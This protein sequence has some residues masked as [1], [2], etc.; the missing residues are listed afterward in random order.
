MPRLAHVGPL[1]RLSLRPIFASAL[2]SFAL[3]SAATPT[4][5]VQPTTTPPVI[6]GVIRPG[7]WTGTAHSDA[8]RQVIPVEEADPTERT[9]FWVTFDTNFIYVAIRAHDSDPARIPAVSLARDQDDGSDD[10]LRI[11]IDPF[12][13]ANDGYFFALTAAGG[14]HDGLIQNKSEGRFEWDGIWHGKA[15]V[16]AAGWSAEFAIPAKTISFDRA[17]ADWGFNVGRAIRSKNEAMRWSGYSRLKS[18]TSL[19][20]LGTLRGLAGLQQGRGLDFKPYASATRRSAPAPDEKRFELNPGFDLIW[21]LTP[22]LAATFTLNTDFAD[23]EVDQRRV[24]LGRFPLFF[25]E[26]RAFFTQDAPLFSFAGIREDPLPF[27][28]RRIGLARDGTKVDLL[29][30]AKLTGRAGPLTLGLLDVQLDEHAGIESKNL[31]VGRAALNV[32]D[33]SSV[34]LIATHGDPRHNG[35]N[36]LVGADFNYVNNRFLG[37]KVL[38]LHSAVQRSESDWA[39]GT[40]TAATFEIDFPNDPLR[41][42]W[43]FNRISERFD[44]ALGFVSR[45]GIQTAHLF[46]AWSWNWPNSNRVRRATAFAETKLVADLDGRRL[47]QQT[48]LGYEGETAAGDFFNGQV[49]RTRERLDAPFQIWP[50]VIVPAG[51]YEWD[52]ART[53]LASTR[54]RPV[55]LRLELATGGFLSGTRDE[56]MVNIAWRPS[57]RVELS[58][59]WLVNDVD[60]PT[61]RFH[62]RVASAR[63]LWFATP[64]L[65]FSLLGQYDN[66][67]ESLG[68]NFRVRWTVQPGNEVFF[69][70][71]QGYDTS[72]DRFRPRGNETSL[73]GAW[74]FRF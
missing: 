36:T 35:D 70:V 34:G 4:L 41:L 15:S 29:G 33:E 14:K 48:W 27:F 12:N 43:H 65:Q 10:L 18:S 8:F 74:T 11:V 52:L 62:L 6:D 71:N 22:S 69:V 44:P 19:P 64:D 72:L 40:G 30:G 31:F 25:P 42:T 73:K 68:V 54:A 20:D 59:D 32:L 63:A 39:G 58:T 13:R 51:D 26:K 37:R 1:M 16:D 24:N 47:D 53:I 49:K 23:A 56:Y 46:N 17:N 21:H 45:T 2:L 7:E 66:L 67:S 60:L 9:E 61:G 55:N 28:S 5:D 57:A 38:A 3:A 50:G